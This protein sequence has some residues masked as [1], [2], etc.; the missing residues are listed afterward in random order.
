LSSQPVA[1]AIIGSSFSLLSSFFLSF[2]LSLYFLCTFFVLSLY[3]LCTFFVL[4]ISLFFFSFAV[5]LKGVLLKLKQS[6]LVSKGKKN[7]WWGTSWQGDSA[8][9]VR[10]KKKR[11]ENQSKAKEFRPS[12]SLLLLLLLASWLCCSAHW[13]KG[14]HIFAER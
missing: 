3:F 12:T 6:F 4:F 1:D 14:H 5:W 13:V 11:K 8:R 7:M 9:Q 10:G 2:L